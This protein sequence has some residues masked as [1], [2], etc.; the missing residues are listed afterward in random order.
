M[1]FTLNSHLLEVIPVIV[2]MMG[3]RAVI[4][5]VRDGMTVVVSYSCTSM[6]SLLIK[7]AMEGN[8]YKRLLKETGRS[9]GYVPRVF[10]DSE[11]HDDVVQV[12]VDTHGM[13]TMSVPDVPTFYGNG[14]IIKGSM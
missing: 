9:V 10:Y 2:N 11:H 6:M 3:G 1:I 5:K 4:R 7:E 12:E 8:E 14:F 13:F